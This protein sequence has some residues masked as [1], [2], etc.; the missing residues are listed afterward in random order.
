MSAMHLIRI[1]KR[2]CGRALLALFSIPRL[3]FTALPENQFV[4]FDEQ[5]KA[6]EEDKVSFVYLSKTAP[7]GKKAPSV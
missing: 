3:E 2:D 5:I 6:L 7:N 1:P 4:V